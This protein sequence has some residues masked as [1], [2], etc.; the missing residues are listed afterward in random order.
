MK[1]RYKLDIAT[2]ADE[3]VAVPLEAAGRFN[4]VITINETMKDILELLAEDKTEEELTMAM[5]QKYKDVSKEEMQK[6]IH[7]ICV[8]LKNE[9]ILD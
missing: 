2:V 1:L 5:M 8:D 9:G 4:G 6:S 3:I 7:T